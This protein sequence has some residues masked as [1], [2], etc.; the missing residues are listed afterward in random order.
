MI[1]DVVIRAIDSEIADLQRI[2]DA[3]EEIL[4]HEK[5]QEKHD[6]LINEV[7]RLQ[8]RIAKLRKKREHFRFG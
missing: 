7:S 5:S 8:D 2:I 4:K 3:D 1:T 6:Q